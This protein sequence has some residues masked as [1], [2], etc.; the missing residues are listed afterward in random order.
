MYRNKMLFCILRS[1]INFT[2]NFRPACSALGLT[3]AE[4]RTSS[5]NT[6]TRS[7]VT[8]FSV[9]S[10]QFRRPRRKKVFAWKVRGTMNRNVKMLAINPVQVVYAIFFAFC[11]NLQSGF[12]LAATGFAADR[13]AFVFKSQ[14]FISS[15]L[16]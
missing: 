6:D 14:T 7:T 9:G 16:L 12:C 1:V 10:N 11:D 8:Q 5:I 15:L 3:A 2:S 13:M 4:K